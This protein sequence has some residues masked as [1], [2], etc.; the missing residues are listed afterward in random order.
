MPAGR[1]ALARERVRDADH[2]S[3]HCADAA[4]AKPAREPF[5]RSVVEL[6]VAVADQPQVA[7]HDAVRGKH[8]LDR[9]RDAVARA[10]AIQERHREQQFLVG[11]G[12]PR[13]VAGVCVEDAA[14]LGGRNRG[15]EA[16]DQPLDPDRPVR[17]SGSC[18]G[19][20]GRSAA[21]QR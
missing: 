19:R 9:G 1:P 16:A 13:R 17:A 20:S 2:R 8:A 18:R 3:A 10:E 4:C 7:A 6:G 5:Q 21:R 12:W 14:A 11:G 15:G